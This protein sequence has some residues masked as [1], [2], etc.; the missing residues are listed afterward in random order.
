MITLAIMFPNIS[1][2]A[3][4]LG[5]VDIR[6]Y[7]LAYI[8]GTIFA[9]FYIK[10]LNRNS[11]IIEEGEKK[12]FYDD[13][14]FYIVIGVVAGGRLGFVLFYEF[15][16]FLQHPSHIF[17][18]WQGGMSYHGGLIGVLIA[19]Y[20]VGRKYKKPFLQIVDIIAPAVPIGVFLGRIA[21]F[22]NGELYGKPTDLPWGVYFPNSLFIARHPSQLY[23]AFLEGI[24]IF[25][26]LA[27]MWKKKA[28]KTVGLVCSTYSVLYGTFRIIV[29]FVREPEIVFWGIVS[30][31]QFL[32]FFMI[33]AGLITIYNVKRKNTTVN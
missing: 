15:S 13:S 17:F 5:G 20:F 21:N 3:I 7:S 19:C 24:V 9:L 14:L 11:G 10:Y 29:E 23:E 6:W 8:V 4:S 2:V 22:I 33:L 27:F 26:I 16:Y 12:S 1:P 25:I 28:Y 31:G 18:L 32:S 30:M